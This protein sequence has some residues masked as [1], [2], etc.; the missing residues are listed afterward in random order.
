MAEKKFLVDINLN[1][2]ELKQAVLENQGLAP[3]S[4]KDGQI[5]YSTESGNKGVKVYKTNTM[6]ICRYY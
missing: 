2:N 6:Y 4:P 3:T 5:Y 1:K